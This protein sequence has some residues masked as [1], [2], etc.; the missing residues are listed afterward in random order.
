MRQNYHIF[1]KYCHDVKEP[2]ALTVNGQP[3]LIVMSYEV[4]ERMQ[5][6]KS[7]KL[8]I[9]NPVHEFFEDIDDLNL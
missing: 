4:Y 9:K 1:S 7:F 8:S 6:P 5:N 2:V 3:D